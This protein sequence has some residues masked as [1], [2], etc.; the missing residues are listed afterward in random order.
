M[1]NDEL[2]ENERLSAY[3][4]FLFNTTELISIEEDIDENEL[5]KS[6]DTDNKY[7]IFNRAFKKIRD[8]TNNK[9]LYRSIKE[10][11]KELSWIKY[12]LLVEGRQKM[13]DKNLKIETNST[14][15]E[16]VINDEM[17]ATKV[18]TLSFK[19]VWEE[20]QNLKSTKEFCKYLKDNPHLKKPKYLIDV[21]FFNN[22]QNTKNNKK[23]SSSAYIK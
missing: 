8:D 5:D 16:N 17:S 15:T 14:I 10:D 9:S 4:D 20:L 3:L 1:D 21:G 6:A 7:E 13:Y 11:I 22:N 19:Y 23:K 12:Q 2:E 18:E